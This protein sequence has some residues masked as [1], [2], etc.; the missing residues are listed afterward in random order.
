MT[1]AK[2]PSKTEVEALAKIRALAD[3]CA[4]NGMSVPQAV[5]T[6][7]AF[8]VFKAS[9]LQGKAYDQAI[10]QV[11]AERHWDSPRP[12]DPMAGVQPLF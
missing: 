12:A 1:K 2:K 8:N 7:K 10:A 4:S 6:L 5:K 11:I 3:Q 9:T